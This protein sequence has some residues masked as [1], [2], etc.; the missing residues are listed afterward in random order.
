MDAVVFDFGGVF[1]ASPFVAI[2][3]ASA[4][5][6]PEF[7]RTL[8]IVFGDYASDTNHPWHRIERGEIDIMTARTEIEELGRAEGLALDLFEMLQYIGSSGGV[9]DDMIDCV[10]R[11]RE[12]GLKTAILTNN[13]A[14]GR[15]FWRP[16]LPLELFDAVV[17]SSE[18]GMRKPNPA[19][20]LHTLTE[21]GGVEPARAVFLDDF[22]GNIVAAR[23]VG[24]VGV[25][26]EEDY[27]PAIAEVDA[28]LAAIT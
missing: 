16:M 1:M 22:E 15:D 2:R 13:I 6:G 5:K 17:D 24:M 14:E 25:L 10:R 9:R 26:V 28:L 7:A 20:Y 23:G 12:R 11:V 21:L 27:A 8:D 19:I 4:E 3:E 18:V